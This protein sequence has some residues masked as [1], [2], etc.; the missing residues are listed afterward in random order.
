MKNSALAFGLLFV[1][2]TYTTTTYVLETVA[3]N[4]DAGKKD[5]LIAVVTT[6]V[7]N[8]KDAYKT[9]AIYTSKIMEAL[10]SK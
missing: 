8:P 7:S 2:I 3:Y 6:E 1:L 5:Q 10:Q 4:L 9:A